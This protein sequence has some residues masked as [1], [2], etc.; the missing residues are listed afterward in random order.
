MCFTKPVDLR[1]EEQNVF[2]IGIYMSVG[3]VGSNQ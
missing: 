2:H 3:E 1:V